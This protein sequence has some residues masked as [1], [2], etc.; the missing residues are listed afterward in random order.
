VIRIFVCEKLFRLYNSTIHAA[1]NQFE[2]SVRLRRTAFTLIELLVVIAIIAILIGLLVP[3][4]QKVRE[5]AARTQCQ[6]NLKQIG[7]ALHGFHDA[8]KV[9]PASGW[10][11]VG[12][13]NP[14]GK[15]VGWRPLT[16][17][18]VDQ[19]NLQKRY[20]FNVNWWEGGNLA[21]ASL[22]VSVYQCPSVPQR[23][24]V[25]F[26]VAKSPR[27]AMTFPAPL[28]PTDYEA[29]MGVQ[30]ASINATL[31]NS[32]NRFSVMY[33]NSRTRLVQIT[34][35]ASNTIM[36]VECAAR[37]LVYRLGTASPTLSND[38]GIAWAD[39]EG[40]F[41]VDGASADGT[42]EGCTPGNGCV[43]AMNKK[44]DNEP[45][46]FH[47]GGTHFLFADGHVQFISQSI[48]LATFAA[49]CTM[50]ANEVVA[51]PDW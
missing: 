29:I 11:T 44:N 1:V 37:P 24:D 41:S 28:A 34:D 14:A 9:M 26:A 40:P 38:Q 13:G 19:E 33:R 18:Y 49:L 50:S 21:T 45:F 30:P 17:P 6:N 4:V 32:T 20:D 43:F 22:P 48:P 16:L 12:P 5:A 8:N 2:A 46:G 27:P 35:G 10:T 51:L 42:Q 3:A 36:V 25:L 39:N 7:L 23:L 47:A 31:Y 15:Y